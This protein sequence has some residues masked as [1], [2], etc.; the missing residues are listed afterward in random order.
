MWIG[1]IRLTV[2]T[3]DAPYAGTDSLLQA[4]I[5]RDGTELRLLNLDYATEDDHERGAIRNYDYFGP[6]R[7]PR[8][9]DKTPSLPDGIGRIPMPYPGYG[10]EF[11]DGLSDHLSIPIYI[12]Y[13]SINYLKM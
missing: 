10:F 9:N 11:S 12:L 6:T 1:A 13:K 2:Q 3:L 4:S 8:R 5:R 7:L